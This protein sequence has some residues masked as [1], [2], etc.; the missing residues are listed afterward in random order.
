LEVQYLEPV[1]CEDVIFEANV[2]DVGPKLVVVDGVC[3]N[4]A[5]TTKLVSG[6]GSFNIYKNPQPLLHSIFRWSVNKFGGPLL[7]VT[8]L[9]PIVMNRILG[10]LKNRKK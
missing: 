4:K 8:R 9:N 3:W 7:D 5:R 2:V 1:P 6:R 10:Q